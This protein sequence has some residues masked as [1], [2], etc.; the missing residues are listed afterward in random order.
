MGSGS[1]AIA[2][3]GVLKPPPLSLYIHIPWCA[4]KCPYCDFNSHTRHGPIQELA[5][6]DAL[7]QDLRGEQKLVAGRPLQTIFIGGGT[8]SLFSAQ[9]IEGLLSGVAEVMALDEAL[10][11]TL[12]ANPGA[13][14]SERLPGYREAGI[15][16]LSLGIQSLN[17]DSLQAL[18]R[19]HGPDEAV[20]AV[21]RAK[22]AGFERINLDLMFGLPAQTLEMAQG[23]LQAAIG[24]GPSHLSY[25][26]LTLEPNTPFY[27]SPPDL[28]DE[29]RLWQIQQQGHEMLLRAGFQQYEISAFSHPQ[30]QCR[31]NLNYWRFGDYIGIGAGAHGKLSTQDGVIRRRWKRR[32]PNDYLAAA[33]GGV[34]FLQGE[35]VLQAEDLVIE[36]MMNALRLCDGVEAELFSATTGLDLEYMGEP[37]NGAIKKGLLYP[38]DGRLCPTPLGLRFLNDLIAMFEVNRTT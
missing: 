26:Q 23:D 37:L 16:R 8:P 5:Y 31:H 4:R 13:L 6:V 17:P 9:S 14:E 1:P 7:L 25:Y 27:Q 30:E 21:E 12:E 11:I 32:H 28:P 15:N 22:Q 10:E 20:M 2:A 34:P 29:E 3:N 36:F 18:G 38:V 35:R 33:K 24:L 19:I